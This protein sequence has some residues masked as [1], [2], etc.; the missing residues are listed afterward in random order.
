MAAKWTACLPLT[1]RGVIVATSFEVWKSGLPLCPAR[2]AVADF[3]KSSLPRGIVQIAARR[4]AK[5]DVRST[6]KCCSI[7][8]VA[9]VAACSKLQSPFRQKGPTFT[10][11]RDCHSLHVGIHQYLRAVRRQSPDCVSFLVINPQVETQLIRTNHKSGDSRPAA[12]R[13]TG[14]NA[15]ESLDDRHWLLLAAFNADSYSS[16]VST[17]S[18]RSVA[19]K[20][21]IVL[22]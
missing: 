10:M 22:S 16:G 13:G 5:A 20:E 15:C 9:L 3:G 11:I 17:S 6:R 4:T 21:T 19:G 7:I 14:T 18:T 8:S 1:C 12:R 2:G